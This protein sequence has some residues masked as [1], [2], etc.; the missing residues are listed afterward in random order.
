MGNVNVINGHI[1]NVVG[2][3]HTSIALNS[4]P[5]QENHHVKST[6]GT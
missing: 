3:Q 4:R 2:R 5:K 6:L 1:A